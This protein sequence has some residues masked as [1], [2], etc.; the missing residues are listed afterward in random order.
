MVFTS[1]SFPLSIAINSHMEDLAILEQIKGGLSMFRAAIGAVKEA[2]TL[3]PES[4]EKEAATRTL[5]EASKA[6]Q[7][8]EATIAQAFGYELCRCEFPPTVMLKV[9]FKMRYGTRDIDDVYECP[10]CK[11]NTARGWEFEGSNSE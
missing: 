8:S 7:M 10:K 5:E 2:S 3:L 9:G 1:L 6:A 11:Q 4:N